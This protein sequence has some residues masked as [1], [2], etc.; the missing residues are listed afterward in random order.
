VNISIKIKQNNKFENLKKAL[1]MTEQ[2]IGYE[3]TEEARKMRLATSP[4]HTNPR[5]ATLDFWRQTSS[6]EEYRIIQQK[7]RQQ[8]NM[9][10]SSLQY[11]EQHMVI[12]QRLAD[13]EK[14]RLGTR[15]LEHEITE[16]ELSKPLLKRVQDCSLM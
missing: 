6:V 16:D 9:P 13:M 7:R 10:T 1:N 4:H 5:S 12:A 11:K 2:W 3:V 15:F 14:R 8:T